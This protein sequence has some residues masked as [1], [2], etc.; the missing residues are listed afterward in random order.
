MAVIDKL[1]ING[2]EYPIN[3]I[4]IG[5][6]QSTQIIDKIY[7]ANDNNSILIKIGNKIASIVLS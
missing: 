6:G 5:G 7:I 1:N 3:D 2:T 4:R